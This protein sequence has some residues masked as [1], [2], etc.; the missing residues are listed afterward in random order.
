MR[1]EDIQFVPLTQGKFAIID[2]ADRD[3][4]LAFKWRLGTDGY[5]IRTRRVGDGPGPHLIQMHRV[6]LGTPDGLDTDHINE[7]KLDNRRENL[8]VAT[9]SQNKANRGLQA[10]NP[11]G[12]RGVRPW[13]G[14]PRWQA[15]IKVAGRGRHLGYFANAE[16]AARAYDAA[17]KE[18]FGEYA[19]LN[20]PESDH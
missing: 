11:S 12:F 20:F 18:A 15:R 2:Y 6:V 8:R 16:D 19:R 7:R 4:V 13:K 1:I 3:R 10:N 9:R 17:A 14:G 5:A